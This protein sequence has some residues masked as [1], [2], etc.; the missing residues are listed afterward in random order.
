M[1]KI[2]T[3]FPP[4]V[5]SFLPAFDKNS[6]DF[7]FYFK[8]AVTNTI[9][10]IA[11]LHVSVRRQDTNETILS[12]I[13]YPLDIIFVKKQGDI[14]VDDGSL[15]VIRYDKDKGYYYF[16]FDSSLFSKA[17]DV[18]Y[19]IQIRVS[20]VPRPSS[21]GTLSE[22]MNSNLDNFSEWSIVTTVMP[23]TIPDFGIQGLSE[24][25]S[26]NVNSS[27]YNFVGMYEPKDLYKKEILSSYIMN[28][29]VYTDYEDRN[30]WKL[31][32]SSGQKTIGIYEKVNIE[33]VFNRDLEKNQKYVISF[34][35]KTKNLYTKT[36]YYKLVAA[37]PTIEMFNSINL[38]PKEDEGKIDVHVQAKQILMSPT[39]GTKVVYI[40]DDP[41]TQQANLEFSHAA[42]NGSIS[43][44][45]NFSLNT[46]DDKWILQSKVK[47]DRVFTTVEEAY[48]N[49]FIEMTEVA[50]DNAFRVATRIK[51]CCMKID[52]NGGYALMD[53]EGR[54]TQQRSDWE[55]RIIARK[56]LVSIIPGREKNVVLLSQNR[57]FKTKEVIS[58]Q[59]EYY[60]FLKENQGYMSLDV[61]KVYK[62]AKG[63]KTWL[64][65]QE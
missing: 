51:L 39:P 13:T 48:D 44:N 35:I 64:S 19:K 4:Q 30:T 31:Y 28:I 33:E 57:V 49:P 52:L 61:Q 62:S 40:E 22:W 9:G 15:N 17:S 11:E 47:I 21:D 18:A 53:E 38:K 54:V 58:P 65:Y 50:D 27:G 20:T 16:R 60:I 36:K 3:I 26:N 55:Y 63:V 45:S 5:S 43:T 56:E 23:I 34:T 12:R 1:T 46:D 6:R 37:Y 14:T 10:Q 59:E 42:I 32:A 29:F 7:K 24:S 41:G 25:D 8:P 2:K